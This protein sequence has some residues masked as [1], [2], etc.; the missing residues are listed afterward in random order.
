MGFRFR[1]RIKVIPGV[2]INL[3]KKSASISVGQPGATLNYGKNGVKGT[4]GIPGTG[5]SYEHRASS[6]QN[7]AN[8]SGNTDREHT[9]HKSWRLTMPSQ[10]TNS[11]PGEFI[12]SDGNEIGQFI[13]IV[14]VVVA[15]FFVISV[16]S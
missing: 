4:A 11:K 9:K 1:K 12:Q 13:K 15:I 7:A 14:V 16:F 5:I 6:G 2:H 10:N 8:I 3:A